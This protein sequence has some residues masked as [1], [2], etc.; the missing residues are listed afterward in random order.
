MQYS[1]VALNLGGAIKVIK[2][3][4]TYGDLQ[5]TSGAGAKTISLLGPGG[6]TLTF[7]KGSVVL[8]VI[9]NPTVAFA[10]GSLSAMTMSIGLAGGS[11]TAFVSAQTVA[12]LTY[13]RSGALFVAGA[14]HVDFG[15]TAV[16]T[17][18]SDTC[19]A[20]TAGTVDIYVFVAPVSTPGA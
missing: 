14:T 18:S 12:A 13:F 16:F 6:T 5:A 2:F 3:T 11:A 17:P 9:I 8:G 7:R 10:G 15:L 4:L 20:A 19:S 1:E